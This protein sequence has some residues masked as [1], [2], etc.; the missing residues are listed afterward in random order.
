[1]YNQRLQNLAITIDKVV[2]LVSAKTMLSYIC[3]LSSYI[4][5]ILH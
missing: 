2:M 3:S 1:M 5:F 4:V